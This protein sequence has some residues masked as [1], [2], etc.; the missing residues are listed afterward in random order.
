MLMQNYRIHTVSRKDNN[1]KRRFDLRPNRGGLKRLRYLALGVGIAIMISGCTMIGPDFIKPKAA[2][3]KEWIEAGD[4]RIKTEKTDYSQ[5][6]TVFN[7]PVLNT[8][9]DKAYQ[10]NLT[11]QIAGIRILEARAQ[12]GIAVGN[13][14]PQQQAGLAGISRTDVSDNTS[15]SLG[16]D[17]P[18]NS[19]DLGFFR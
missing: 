9:I 3:E 15:S 18:F 7:D 11:L 5:W 10:Q 12:L 19:L 1:Y 4:T 13:L 2:V 17:S 8:L 6:W 14:Y 16:V